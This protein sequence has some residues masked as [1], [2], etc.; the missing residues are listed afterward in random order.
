MNYITG[1][2]DYWAKGYPAPNIES[3][4][5]RPFGRLI[6]E[7]IPADSATLDWGCGQ[8]ATSLYMAQQGLTPYGIDISETDIEVARHRLPEHSANF[9]VVPFLPTQ[10]QLY[11]DGGFGLVTAV[12]SLYYLDSEALP[13]AVDA[14]WNSMNPGGLLYATMMSSK[15]WFFGNSSPAGNGMR[16]VE[17]HGSRLKVSD[18]FVNFMESEQQ[19]IDLF[20]R[21]QTVA[22]GYY[23]ACWVPGEGSDH[24]YFFLGRK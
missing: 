18:Y 16:K 15:N 2:D 17:I 8:G 20:A 11:F 10:G 9:Q 14:I 23:D 4:V 24:H 21:F 12:Q 3:H 6:R 1:N 13:V 5:F 19:M 22:V 7:R